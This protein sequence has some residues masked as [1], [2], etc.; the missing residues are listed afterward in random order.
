MSPTVI[1][2]GSI[3]GSGMQAVF[4]CELA[5]MQCPGL[6]AT[7]QFFYLLGRQLGVVVVFSGVVGAAMFRAAALGYAVLNILLR[8]TSEQ[9]SRIATAR[10]VATVA[11]IPACRNWSMFQGERQTMRSHLWAAPMAIPTLIGRGFPWPTF[12][13]PSDVDFRPEASQR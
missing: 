8:C 5:L 6:I 2:H 13:R 1:S 3:H 10:I 7:A 11:N 12:V 9:M 4:T